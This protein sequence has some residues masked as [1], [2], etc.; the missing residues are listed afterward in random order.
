M[1]WAGPGLSTRSDV[2]WKEG[3]PHPSPVYSLLTMNGP[4]TKIRQTR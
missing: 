4:Q 1:Q 2:E 3:L